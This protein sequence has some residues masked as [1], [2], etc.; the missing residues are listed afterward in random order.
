MKL[1]RIMEASWR[2]RVLEVARLPIPENQEISVHYS[3]LD[4]IWNRNKIII[5][6]VFISA[7]ATEIMISDDIEPCFVNE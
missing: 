7:L 3:C 2:R 1:F 6:D 4:E 5:D